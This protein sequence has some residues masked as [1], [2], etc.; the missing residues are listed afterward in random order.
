MIASDAVGAGSGGLLSA[1][2]TEAAARPTAV[3]RM[4]RRPP[5]AVVW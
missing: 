2:D 1:L 5:R 3:R 4:R